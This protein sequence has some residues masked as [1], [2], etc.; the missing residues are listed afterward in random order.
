MLG[1]VFLRPVRSV[2]GGQNSSLVFLCGRW[3]PISV[4]FTELGGMTPHVSEPGKHG[5]TYWVIL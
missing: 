5:S 1:Y 2:S 4:K 3:G